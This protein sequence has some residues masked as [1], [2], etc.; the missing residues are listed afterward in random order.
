MSHIDHARNKRYRTDLTDLRVTSVISADILLAQA[1]S[2]GGYARD[3]PKQ[4]HFN[5]IINFHAFKF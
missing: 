2:L 4:K 1:V 5:I 3:R